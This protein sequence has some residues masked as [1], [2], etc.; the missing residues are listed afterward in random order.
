MLFI[1]YFQLVSSTLCCDYLVDRLVVSRTRATDSASAAMLRVLCD[2]LRDIFRPL[3]TKMT[4]TPSPSPGPLSHPSDSL[5]DSQAYPTSSTP[6]PCP[7]ASA[8]GSEAGGR[9][10]KIERSCPPPLAPQSNPQVARHPQASC[11]VAAIR[12]QELRGPH[13]GCFQSTWVR[14][15]RASSGWVGAI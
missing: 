10:R 11:W 14:W 2:H 6:I 9:G 7:A 8:P 4:V 15:L 12:V 3:F 13:I 5:S 1:T